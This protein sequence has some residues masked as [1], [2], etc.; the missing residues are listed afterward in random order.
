MW[1]YITYILLTIMMFPGLAALGLYESFW[2]IA[3][4]ALLAMATILV[5]SLANRL[6]KQRAVLD[7]LFEQA[8]EGVALTNADRRVTRV[9]REFSR[10]FGYSPAQAV[11]QI[12]TDLIIPPELMDDGLKLWNLAG[13]GQRVEAETVRRRMDGSRLHIAVVLVPFRT[14]GGEPAIYAIYRDITQRKRSEEALRASEARWRAI[15]E[16]SAVGISLTGPN[17]G[18]IATN[19]AYQQMLGYTDDELRGMSAM[20]ITYQEDREVNEALLRALWNETL[21]RFQYEKRYRRKDGELI[22][23]RVTVSLAPGTEAVPRFSLAIVEDITERERALELLKRNE[24]YL[25]ESQGQSRVGSWAVNVS[26]RALVF[27]ST[28]H[29]RIFGFE[30][31]DAALTWDTALQRV[32][33]RDLPWLEQTFERAVRE[34]ED[35]EIE[36]RIVLPDG[37]LKYCRS[38][39]HPVVKENGEL[40]EFIGTVMDVT[41]SRRAQQELLESFNQ[42]RAL[43]GRLQSAREE[44]RTRVA[45]EIH[46]ELGQALTAIKI[47]LA[48]TLRE[49]PSDA[50]P[51]NPRSQSI[52]KLL[53]E[54]IQSVRKIATELRPGVLDDLGLVAAVEWAAEE[55]QART[56]TQCEVSLPS[57]DIALDQERGTALFRILQETLTNVARHANATRVDIRL[58]AENDSL[59]LE[60]HDDGRGIG[61]KQVSQNRSLGILGMRERAL[62]VGGELRISGHPGKG[63]T[64]RVRVPQPYGEK[65]RSEND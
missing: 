25:A 27:W 63:T 51:Q 4:T 57:A 24:A 18:F 54:A 32:H 30:P 6:H 62:L 48:A 8:P 43:A 35:F 52:L 28:E 12:L 14:P 56:G 17:G 11:G 31:G 23:A 16:N 53:D 58:A 22:W 15:F 5:V 38:I 65:V 39:G 1:S 26:P 40:T 34:K 19:R 61:E 7:E 55:F 33:P 29:Y 59:V 46:D 41:E 47:D 45:R 13:Q 44:E 42:L 21:P 9:N 60:V 36:F 37:T 50:W 64:V 49:L 3:L 10:I 2:I 20:E